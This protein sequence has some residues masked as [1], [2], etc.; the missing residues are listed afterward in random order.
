MIGLFVVVYFVFSVFEVNNVCVFDLFMV[1]VCSGLLMGLLVCVDLMLLFLKLISYLFGVWGFIV[2]IYFVIVGVSNVVNLI[3]GFD[4]F[5][6][7]LVVFVGV[8]FGV[9][10]YVMGSV[11]YLKYLLFLYILG[12]GELLIFCFVMGGVGFVFFWYNMYF[13]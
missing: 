13:V 6:I 1:W 8:L 4:G 10:V 5:V 12:V 2:L 9:F 7:M 3:D 11:V